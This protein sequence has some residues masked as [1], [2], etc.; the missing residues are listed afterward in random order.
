MRS[1]SRIGAIMTI[2]AMTGINCEG[3]IE[4]GPSTVPP[5]WTHD[6]ERLEKAEAKRARKNAKRASNFHNVVKGDL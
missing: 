6:P 3:P 4:R 2:M 1:S 5:S